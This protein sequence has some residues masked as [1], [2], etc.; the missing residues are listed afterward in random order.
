MAYSLVYRPA[1]HNTVAPQKLTVQK[2]IVGSRGNNALEIHQVQAGRAAQDVRQGN[3]VG[4]Q[5]IIR[6]K[7]ALAQL[8]EGRPVA[9]TKSA[10][11][12][13]SG[14]VHRVLPAMNLSA[15]A[16]TLSRCA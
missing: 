14:G 1:D 9:R 2:G 11:G 3:A 10:C 5:G 4:F 16:R 7:G 12:D 6:L 13:S 15:A 8:V